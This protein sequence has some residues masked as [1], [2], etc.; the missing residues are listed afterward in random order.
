MSKVADFNPPHLHLAPPYGLTPVEFCGNLW[1]QKMGVPELSCGVVCVILCL[2]VLTQYQ[3]VTD[4]QTD[5]Q[6]DGHMT[7]EYTALA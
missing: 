2:A 4:R 7:T 5:G 1:R 3:L 6:T